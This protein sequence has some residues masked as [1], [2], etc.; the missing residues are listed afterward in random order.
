MKPVYLLLIL[1]FVLHQDFWY[2][3]DASLALGFLPVG[4]FYHILFSLA[5]G[6]TWFLVI[7]YAWPQGLDEG[8]DEKDKK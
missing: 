5:A 6:F 3:N 2:W 1:L 4:L 7:K 8:L